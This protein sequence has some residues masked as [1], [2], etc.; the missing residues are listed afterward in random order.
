[1][2]HMWVQLGGSITLVL[3]FLLLGKALKRLF[4]FFQNY[5]IPASLL[6]G[7]LA[8]F[9][10]AAPFETLRIL[11][12]VVYEQWSSWPGILIN[13]V[14]AALFLGKRILGLK[15]TWR[16]AGPQV[17]FGQTLAWGQYVVGL[18]L[19]LA[20]LVPVFQMSPLSG[21]LIEIS[22]EG[23][24]GTAAGLGPVFAELGFAEGA[25]LAIGLATVGIVVGIV[26][27]I[28][29]INW[30]H[31]TSRTVVQGA[32][33]NNEQAQLKKQ[34]ATKL[35]DEAHD[36]PGHWLDKL[37]VLKWLV[38][39]GY[40]VI[41]IGLGRLLLDGLIT[42]ENT[43]WASD[44][45]LELMGSMPLFPLAMIG[46]VLLQLVLA[47]LKVPHLIDRNIIMMIS[48]LALDILIISAVATVSL[49]VLGSYFVP[50]LLI[51][52]AG[53]AWNL[54]AFLVLAPRLIP[55]YWFERG[56]GDYGQ[57][58]GMTATGLLL[59]KIADP[60]NDSSALE[61]FG[62]KQLFFEPIVGGGI[63][64]ASSLILIDQ[65]GPVAMLI[66]TA[67][68]MCGWIVFGYMQFHHKER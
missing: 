31:R 33:K 47:K 63:F 12:D 40:I 46:G 59:M 28:V 11:P 65:F 39:I 66:F 20:V 1:M 5:Y 51:A 62:Y 14:F 55:R 9:V 36:E 17:V 10:F 16:L 61:S 58:M 15:E 19:A 67:A 18:L 43:T 44:G 54:F 35:D 50:F 56:V 45:G 8:L 53:I 7:V 37:P 6:A 13:I 26:T 3:I 38:H 22:F 60:R 24:H 68:V 64:T 42:L 2:E 25:D 32:H 27:G 49:A 57:S 29:L 52:A 30:A 34:E 23:G 4:P 48:S 41:A 21:A